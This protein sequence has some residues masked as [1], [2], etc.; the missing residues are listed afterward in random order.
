MSRPLVITDCDEV[1][2]HMIA[3]FRDWLG[4]SQGVTFTMNGND[5][6]HALRYTATGELVQGKEIWRLL[7]LFFV[8]EMH[9][10]SPINGALAAMQQLG[11]QADV[12]VLTNL[13]DH[14]NEARTSQLAGHGFDLKVFTNQGPKGPALQKI[15][16]EYGPSRA[17][18]ID[19]L[20]QHHGSVAE[21]SPHV[22]RL[23]LCGEPLLAPHINCAHQA[24]DAHA[25]IDDWQQALPWL[26][27]RL[28]GEAHV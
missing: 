8:S 26:L 16:A 7:D 3:P 25:R 24:G 23:H 13:G 2:L 22:H 27:E 28:Y 21:L 11:E 4:E 14:F 12:V 19:D 5:F 6:A 1:L 15:V 9:R 10:Q 17:V 20:A 18:F